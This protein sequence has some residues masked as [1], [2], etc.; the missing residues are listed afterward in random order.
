MSD[1][2]RPLVLD[3]LVCGHCGEPIQPGG[4]RFFHLDVDD[5]QECSRADGFSSLAAPQYL[6]VIWVRYEGAG[7]ES[8]HVMVDEVEYVLWR[9]GP[10][11]RF[12][13]DRPLWSAWRVDVVKEPGAT[14]RLPSL[15]LYSHDGYTNHADDP[16]L[17]TAVMP[18]L[19]A[20]W[21]MDKVEPF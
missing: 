18:A 7:S 13:G 6:E 9:H 3:R 5:S 10:D 17:L 4:S 16:R 1:S 20:Y 15:T 2:P 14:G 19:V 11:P 21:L 8:Y 12:P